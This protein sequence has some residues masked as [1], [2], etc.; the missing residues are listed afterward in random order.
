MKVLMFGWEFPPHISGG[1]GTACFGLTRS[2]VN[3]DINI[4]FVLPRIKRNHHQTTANNINLIGANEVV[5]DIFNVDKILDKDTL[6]FIP[7]DSPL[8]PYKTPEQYEQAVKELKEE[9]ERRA[10]EGM[11]NLV[12]LS[13]DYSD[14][15]KDEV[16]RYAIVGKRL[17]H[18]GDFDVIHAH[19]WMTYLAAVEAKKSSGRPLVTHM[20]A[21]E[22]DRSGSNPNQE[23]LDIERYGLEQADKIIAVSL[24]TKQMIIDKYG[25]EPNKIVVVHNAVD[26]EKFINPKDI[27]KLP[28]DKIVL[29]LGRITMQK[30]PEYFVDAASLVY[31]KMKNVRFIMA[32]SGDLLPQMIEKVAALGMQDRFHFTGFLRGKDIDRVY[33]ISDLY[34]MPSVSEPFG[35]TPLE[36]IKHNVP[37]I[38]SKQTGAAEILNDV[39]KLDF[40]DTHKLADNIINIMKR[41]ALAKTMVKNCQTTFK[42][43]SW[44]NAALKVKEIY[45]ELVAC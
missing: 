11:S 19:D 21:T 6:E 45:R 4:T 14:N 33:S 27:T 2:L 20:H 32:G 12:S 41:P 18:R 29:F 23:V 15:L 31:N 40:W 24:R 7:I 26:K 5:A 43:I 36:A 28:G 13:G 9:L 44:D 42:N 17:G 38:V 22:Y 25:I 8:S 37:I 1:L 16:T 39:I 34:V 10:A 3:Q 35:I 30:G